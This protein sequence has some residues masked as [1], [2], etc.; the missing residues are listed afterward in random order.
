MKP[1]AG[2]FLLF[3]WL[4]WLSLSNAL[5]AIV[6]SRIT[7]V[8]LS[9]DS[10]R[11][12]REMEVRL[13][14]GDNQFLVAGLPQGLEPESLSLVAA[15]EGTRAL[16][17][18][19]DVRLTTT[20]VDISGPRVEALKAEKDALKQQMDALKTRIA[21]MEI[22][23]TAIRSL[24]DGLGKQPL[25]SG[26]LND[27][28][29]LEQ[30]EQRAISVLEAQTR[31]A[32]E[33]ARLA[34]DLERVERELALIEQRAQGSRTAIVN[35]RASK[36]GDARLHLV[37]VHRQAGW[38]PLYEAELNTKSGQLF[39]R[40][41]AVVRQQTGEDWSAVR[42]SVAMTDRA[43]W[44]PVPELS[45]WQI[46]FVDMPK[47]GAAP[48]TYLEQAVR[49]LAAPMMDTAPV[50]LVGSAYALRFD[51]VEPVN[52]GSGTDDQVITLESFEM[53]S[54]L[55]VRT[56]PRLLPVAVL[57]AE[58][59]Y[60]GEAALPA[61]RL[62]FFRDGQ[63]VGS[64]HLQSLMPEQSVLLSFGVDPLLEVEYRL[65]PEK[66]DE[67]GLIGRHKKVE[68]QAVMT[69]VNRHEQDIDLVVL[70]QLPVA[71]DADISVTPSSSNTPPSQRNFDGHEGVWAWSRTLKPGASFQIDFGYTVTWPADKNVSGF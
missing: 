70:D 44:R 32:Q 6:D 8:T 31:L 63:Q 49:A 4:L 3:G 17:E 21:A 50:E 16:I 41:R 64:S 60:E 55:S 11:I 47:A 36:A 18:R 57:V 67:R 45:T 1:A 24:A 27:D 52:L 58:V 20:A 12:T 71:R 48:D 30:L 2:W 33:Q 13:A 23:L 42:L 26:V 62:L 29:L 10:A 39:W 38:T 66:R 37:Y 65:A 43:S 14:V 59:V 25:E 53:V 40:T 9:P 51:L 5:A 34:H 61:G 7:Q 68:R 19:A 56:A 69:I 46:G 54:K 35:V 28:A 22:R 15:D